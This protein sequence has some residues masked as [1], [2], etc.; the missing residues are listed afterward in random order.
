MYILEVEIQKGSGEALE[1]ENFYCV[2]YTDSKRTSTQKT[3]IP[4]SEPLT[5]KLENDNEDLILQALSNKDSLI[6][7]CLIP[8]SVEKLKAK[9]PEEWTASWF[10]LQ[11]DAQSKKVEK[12]T[13]DIKKETDK[14]KDSEN[15]VT[16]TKATTSKS[17][18]RR[19][20]LLSKLTPSPT[21]LFKKIAKSSEKK[22]QDGKSC[23]ILL[24][25][26]LGSSSS[27]SS[28]SHSPAKPTEFKNENE[29]GNESASYG[30]RTTE[31]SVESQTKVDKLA[32]AASPD[33]V[34][35]KRE[36]ADKNEH[37]KTSPIQEI[38]ADVSLNAVEENDR[39]DTF[40]L[41]CFGPCTIL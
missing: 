35:D 1:S 41:C 11:L 33:S 4:N 27:S 17:K 39:L 23:R 12:Q 10:E 7:R 2:L 22:N 34:E 36:S 16:P 20:T 28:I 13:V 26:R 24:R 18:K 14:E 40:K 38:M 29:N 5:L 21:G 25:Y 30:S 8:I 6:G 9:Q 31:S 15:T 37:E 32:S 19:Q 3:S